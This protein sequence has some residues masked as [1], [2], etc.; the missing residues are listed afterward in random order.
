MTHENTIIEMDDET[1]KKQGG[2]V[3]KLPKEQLKSLFYLFA[4]KPD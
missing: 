1:I 2:V 3:A 4:G